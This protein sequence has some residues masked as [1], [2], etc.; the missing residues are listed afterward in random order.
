MGFVQRLSAI[1]KKQVLLAAAFITVIVML[2]GGSFAAIYKYVDENGNIH[3]T[4]VPGDPRYKL[5]L[6][7]KKGY[8]GHSAD[9][10]AYDDHIFKAA[11]YYGIDPLLVKAVIKIESNFNRHA[12]SRKGAIGLM[13]LM[14]STANDMNVGNPYD[15][16][17]NIF[18]G[19]CYLSRLL[20]MFQG[21]LDLSLAAYNAG[22]ERVKQQGGIPRIQE[23]QDYVRKVMACYK[24]YRKNGQKSSYD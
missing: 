8:R 6:D 12:V 2:P 16:E 22:P 10:A 20:D 1:L 9:P 11:Q 13:Q 7:D 19:T 14:P 18:G 5:W 17:E 4:N 15:A 23:T 21:D 3:L 24:R